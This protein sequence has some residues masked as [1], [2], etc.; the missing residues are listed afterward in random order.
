MVRLVVLTVV[1]VAVAVLFWPDGIGLLLGLA[2]FRLH[3]PDDDHDPPAE[4]AEERMTCARCDGAPSWPSGF[5][6]ARPVLTEESD[7]DTEITIGEHVTRTWV[8]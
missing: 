8:G 1:A 6:M 2:I 4:G 5:V 3:R 7:G